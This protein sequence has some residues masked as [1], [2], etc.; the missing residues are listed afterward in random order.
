MC[1][2]VCGSLT[3]DI[4]Q[5]CDNPMIAGAKD[6]LILGNFEDILSVTRDVGNHLIVT[7][8][9]L[10]AGGAQAFQYDGKN[11]SNEPSFALVKKDFAEVY[12]HSVKFKVFLND[13]ATKQE[14]EAMA[15]GR[16]FAITENNH[17]GPAGNSAF[18]ILRL[19]SGLVLTVHTRNTA[20]DATQGAHDLELKSSEKSPEPHVPAA[21]FLTSFA[22]TKALVDALLVPTI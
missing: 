5:D 2:P 14:L 19:E 10:V 8:L 6:R 13:G 20:D 11:N 17:L 21:F 7:A 4:T 15:K 22:V 3:I 18:E 9:T 16:V 1:P 12:E